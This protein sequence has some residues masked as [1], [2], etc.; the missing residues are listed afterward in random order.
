MSS[1]DVIKL[2]QSIFRDVTVQ[3]LVQADRLIVY[4]IM[5][6]LLTNRM[7]GKFDILPVVNSAVNCIWYFWLVKEF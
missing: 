1:D 4:N 6:Y 7:S 2:V 5:D 3:T